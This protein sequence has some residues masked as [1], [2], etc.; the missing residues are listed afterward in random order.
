MVVEADIGNFFYGHKAE[1]EVA[2][3]AQVFKAAFVDVQ[4]Y[5]F[6]LVY[7][8]HIAGDGIG[9]GYGCGERRC[10]F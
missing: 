9:G 1:P 4:H 8:Y 2:A 7:M 3:A 6:I 10:I 5:V